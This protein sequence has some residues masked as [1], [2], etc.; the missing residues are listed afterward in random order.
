MMKQRKKK[1]NNPEN[2][3]ICYVIKQ[4][5]VLKELS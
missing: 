2:C 4:K 1:I 3:A 5:V